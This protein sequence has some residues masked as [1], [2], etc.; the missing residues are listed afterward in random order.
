[1]IYWKEETARLAKEKAFIV[2]VDYYDEAGVPVFAVRK[3]VKA[4]GMKSGKN[5]Y[6]GVQFEQPLYDGCTIVAYSY[7]LSWTTH[8]DSAF[9]RLIKYHPGWVLSERDLA[10]LKARKNSALE[11]IN[12]NFRFG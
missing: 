11:Y 12:D 4:V 1:M 3:V 7:V 8:N 6:W 5:S 10:E 2:L 9:D